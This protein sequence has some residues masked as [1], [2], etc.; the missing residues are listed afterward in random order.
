MGKTR[1]KSTVTSGVPENS[2]HLASKVEKFEESVKAT[3]DDL[4]QQLIV[5]SQ[6]IGRRDPNSAGSI[7]GRL[8]TFESN[9]KQAIDSLKSEIARFN[10]R[11]DKIE[12]KVDHQRQ[13]QLH[14]AIVIN[15]I[16]EKG[17][18]ESAVD[19][20]VKVIRDAKSEITILP[21]DINF[22]YRLGKKGDDSDRNIRPLAVAFVNRWKRDRIFESKKM[23]KGTKVVISEMLSP[24]KLRLFKKVRDR[25]G[26][27]ECWTWKGNVY[28]SIN[29][30]RKRITN[31]ND[32]E[33]LS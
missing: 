27:R 22:A 13:Q 14:N 3:L 2:V 31:D 7:I 25:V 1:S 11:Q 30:E 24:E 29:G 23:F 19:I 10:E 21:S 17:H 4:K 18:S 6:E 33:K 5:E 15:G 20:V 32:L 26:V 12:R 8:T 28:V 16:P 9:I